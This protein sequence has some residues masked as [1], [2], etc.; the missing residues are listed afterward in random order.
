MEKLCEIRPPADLGHHLTQTQVK[1]GNTAI[2][3]FLRAISFDDE[4]LTSIKDVVRAFKFLAK[5]DQEMAGS[6]SKVAKYLQIVSLS[7]SPQP[8][9]IWSSEPLRRTGNYFDASPSPD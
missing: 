9:P 6:S 7:A 5:K 8:R 3:A 1:L 4:G 2:T